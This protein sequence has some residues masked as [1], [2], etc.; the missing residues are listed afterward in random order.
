MNKKIFLVVFLF[1]QA[2]TI[3]FAQ[4]DA[5]TDS[6]NRYYYYFQFSPNV[7][8]NV[9]IAATITGVNYTIRIMKDSLDENPEI[10]YGNIEYEDNGNPADFLMIDDFDFNGDLDFA[11]KSKDLGMVGHDVYRVFAYSREKR[12]FVEQASVAG[13]GF[14]YLRVDKEKKQLL[15]TCWV[16][17]VPKT[18][19]TKLN[20]MK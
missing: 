5:K 17:G 15:S 8:T 18:C 3:S 10:K 9:A 12:D 7:K 1:L 13:Y 2:L 20:K 6:E 4:T 11:I 16:H 19:V 14:I